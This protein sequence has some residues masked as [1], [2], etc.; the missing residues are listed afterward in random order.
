MTR[1]HLGSLLLGAVV[2]LL[3]PA[4]AAAA[5][6]CGDPQTRPWCDTSLSPGQRAELLLGELTDEEEISLLGGDDLSG[7]L[8]EEGTHTGTSNGIE[9]VGLPTIYLSDGPGGPRSGLATAMPSPLAL[10]ASWDP[11]ASSRDAA[12][13]ADEVIHKG[14]DI[15][16]APTVDIVRTPLAGRVFEA[17]GGEDP[18]LA[19]KLAVP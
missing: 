13:I 3:V 16:F 5:G 11:Q 1:R 12:V 2:A 6:R 15:V 17:I 19:S 9:R 8:G 7:V 14:N 18:L 4:S 10:G